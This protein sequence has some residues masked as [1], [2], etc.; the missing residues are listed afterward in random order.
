MTKNEN[1]PNARE[2]Y[3]KTKGILCGGDPYFCISFDIKK[4]NPKDEKMF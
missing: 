4:K 3:G 2:K 1:E